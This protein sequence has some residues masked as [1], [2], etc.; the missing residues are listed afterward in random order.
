MRINGIELR[1]FHPQDRLMLIALGLRSPDFVT[2]KEL[3]PI[4]YPDPDFE[5]DSAE[6]LIWR[7]MQ[8]IRQSSPE[9]LERL[10][11]RSGWNGGYCLEKATKK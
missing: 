2:A 10:K 9:L 7:R 11:C 5:P 6:M 3:V 8:R 1:N 4:V